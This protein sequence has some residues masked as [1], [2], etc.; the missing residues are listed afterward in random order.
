VE[1]KSLLDFFSGA[2]TV[3]KKKD[4]EKCEDK[5]AKTLIQK[6][7]KKES[8]LVRKKPDGDVKIGKNDLLQQPITDI[9]EISEKISDK[10]KTKKIKTNQQVEGNFNIN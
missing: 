9:E 8:T 1:N 3:A 6:Q 10:R 5:S 7:G 2:K 4:E